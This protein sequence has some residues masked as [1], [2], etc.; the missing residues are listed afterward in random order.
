MEAIGSASFLVVLRPPEDDAPGVPARI[1]TSDGRRSL[2]V[3]LNRGARV[4]A[5][6]PK[7]AR[8][9]R[10]SSRFCIP[11]SS[12]VSEFGLK[13]GSLRSLSS[14]V[15]VNSVSSSDR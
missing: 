6:V 7:A 15:F 9:S 10:S 11:S 4:V 3:P 13:S 8:S 5:L 1:C 12:D 14:E 2:E